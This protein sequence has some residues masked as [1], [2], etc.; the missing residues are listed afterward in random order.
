MCAPE[1]T[2]AARLPEVR[3]L[4]NITRVRLS[5]V[6]PALNE[7]RHIAATLRS[8]RAAL[9]ACEVIVVDGGSHDQT[10]NRA[11][12]F[13]Q[14]LSSPPGRARQ[15]NAGAAAATG[16][17]LLFL[18]ADTCVAADTG[19]ATRRMLGDARII[20]GTF[21]LRFDDAHPILRMYGWF[22]RFRPG[23][24]HY[25][26]Q[27]IVVRRA[28]FE[29]LGGF[30][31]MALM[32]D[33]DF[34][35]RLRRIGRVGIADGYVTTSARRFLEHGIVRQQLFNAVLLTLFHCGVP[36]RLLARFYRAHETACP[37]Q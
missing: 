22:T 19:T 6:V 2:D 30:R 27:G 26:D 9:G 25:G 1:T 23:I 20:G 18:H 4:Q 28:V 37:A 17:V 3:S 24:F 7:E 13:A 5:I 33:V 32:E 10:V 34:L 31:E 15:M 16:D 29:R 36:A 8:I 21:R 14:V 35:R 11:R 12:A